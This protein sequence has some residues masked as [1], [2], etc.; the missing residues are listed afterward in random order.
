MRQLEDFDFFLSKDIIQGEE[1]PF[2]LV[3]RGDNPKNI[4]LEYEGF[5]SIVELYNAKYSDI[6]P[7]QNRVVITDLEVPNYLGGLISTKMSDVPVAIGSV[8]IQVIDTD[9][10]SLS[11]KESRKI[12]TTILRISSIPD[13]L[14]W[15]GQDI[16]SKICIEL[17]GEPTVFIEVE[18]LEENEC[19]IDLPPDI[20]EMLYNVTKSINEGLNNLKETFPQYVQTINLL[21][22]I[23]DEKMSVLQY[24]EKFED[25]IKDSLNDDVFVEEIITVFICGLFE[26]TSLKDRIIRPWREYLEYYS[27][28]HA[29]FSN[30]MLNLDIPENE[31]ILAIKLITTDLLEQ[32]CGEPLVIKVP[33][34]PYPE[35][36]NVQ[37][38]LRNIFSIERIK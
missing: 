8:N 34:A 19:H 32:E 37:V 14:C 25:N 33:V 6:I 27:F 5:Q 12:Y 23:P 7:E 11:L 15:D 35:T 30:P 31:S 10:T 9:G 28:N 24:I 20:K 18:E 2:Y 4:I 21:L 17:K 13:K 1:V 26:Q 16:E 22:G 36:D 29:F 3:W 38:P